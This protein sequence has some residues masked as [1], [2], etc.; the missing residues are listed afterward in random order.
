MKRLVLASGNEGKLGEL[1][2]MLAGMSLQITVQGEF[3]VP[4]V[5]ETGLTFV[6][7]A[8]IK[9]RHACAIT[10][11]PSLADDS[12]LI[13]DALGGAPGLY[14]ARYAGSPTDAAANNAKLLD[15]LRDVP[16]GRRCARFYAVIVLLRH[17]EDPQPLIAEG[18]WEGEI[19]FEPR[20]RGGFGYNPVFFDPLH[21]V[22]AAEMDVELKNK[23][24]H[25]S[26]ALAQLRDRLHT[27]IA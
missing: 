14:S 19:A 18:C 3:G 20:G 11:F 15:M 16:V 1:H 13:V 8:L 2:A 17:A 23:I 6:E 24:S 5:P 10:G 12:G 22:T 9:A 27:L 25:R 4:D 26:R 7:N 21:G